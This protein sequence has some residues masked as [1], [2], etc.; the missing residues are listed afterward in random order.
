MTE[1]QRGSKAAA[2]KAKPSAVAH[3]GVAGNAYQSPSPAAYPRLQ[4]YCGKQAR[5]RSLLG[6][7][8][9]GTPY[10]KLKSLRIWPTIFREWPNFVYK[11][12]NIE[13]ERVNVR[14]G[15]AFYWGK[16]PRKFQGSKSWWGKFPSFPTFP[17]GGYAHVCQSVTAR[18]RDV[19]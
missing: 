8:T 18:H 12:S 10:Q 13:R 6:V 17:S 3:C 5:T 7:G 15:S 11:K 1:E 9:K 2:G 14:S 16:F 4:G 19:G